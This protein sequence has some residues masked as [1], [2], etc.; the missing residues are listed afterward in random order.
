MG[1]SRTVRA[2]L[3]HFVMIKP[4][5][6][7]QPGPREALETHKIYLRSVNWLGDGALQDVP[8]DGLELFAKVRSTRPPRGS[9]CSSRFFNSWTPQ[10]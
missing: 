5:L 8:G 3:F 9:I 4:T 6:I 10:R 7:Y 1:A 2:T